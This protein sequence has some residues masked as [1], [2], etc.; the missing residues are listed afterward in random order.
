MNAITLLHIAADLAVILYTGDE[1]R[2]LAGHR[3]LL[4]VLACVLVCAG[5]LGSICDALRYGST[6]YGLAFA[7]GVAVYCATRHRRRAETS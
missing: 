7:S 2:R 5:A 3:H 4:L 1:L 6:I